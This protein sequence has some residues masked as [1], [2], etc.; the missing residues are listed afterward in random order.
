MTSPFSDEQIS[1]YLDGEL[2]VEET[3]RVE[4]QLRENADLRRLC[5][6]LRALRSTLQALPATELSEDLAERVLRQAERRMLL[7]DEE[8]GESLDGQVDASAA[9]VRRPHSPFARHPWRLVASV[10]AGLAALLLIMLWLP[11]SGYLSNSREV[12]TKMATDSAATPW[13]EEAHRDAYHDPASG[14][15]G[16]EL[17]FAL[18]DDMAAKEEAAPLAETE[19]AATGE[20]PERPALEAAASPDAAERGGRAMG[21]KAIRSTEPPAPGSASPVAGS[22]VRGAAPKSR[23]AN[24]PARQMQDS[25]DGIPAG[26]DTATDAPAV[27]GLGRAMDSGGTGYP[28]AALGSGGSGMGSGMGGY[29]GSG[30]GMMGGMGGAGGMDTGMGSGMGMGMGGGGK[31]NV[32]GMSG[33]PG[34][35]MPA[36][37]TTYPYRG[38]ARGSGDSGVPESESGMG[39]AGDAAQF[40]LSEPV[41]MVLGL[42][43]QQLPRQ[44]VAEQLLSE[45]DR[46]ESLILRVRVPADFSPPEL[47]TPVDFADTATWSRFAPLHGWLE[48]E[49]PDAR[50]MLG[51]RISAAQT[52]PQQMD[53]GPGERPTGSLLVVEGT[54]E[55]V[56]QSLVRLIT[57]SEVRLDAVS[58]LRGRQTQ[59]L[60]QDAASLPLVDGEQAG[61]RQKAAPHDFGAGLEGAMATPEPATATLDAQSAAEDK[62]LAA[63]QV[64]SPSDAAT[65][66]EETPP[67]LTEAEELAESSEGRR[68]PAA[69][70]EQPLREEVTESEIAASQ[71]KKVTADRSARD[72]EPLKREAGKSPGPARVVTFF[73]RYREDTAESAPAA[74]A[75]EK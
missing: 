24:T 49:K 34:A 56:R 27:L 11:I 31:A 47:S 35:G 64:P 63:G 73:F 17:R 53:Y 52:V 75:G 2:S 16:T 50:R 30:G 9:T 74:P 43:D 60:E 54:P 57:Q 37:S 70:A 40:D 36:E 25:S 29:P 51:E 44:R 69:A 61:V 66:R 14:G 46:H 18:E 15:A 38:E 7:G 22:L 3:A 67:K 41:E 21:R 48:Q 71:D 62:P 19:P 45:L 12:A 55:Q 20:R 26:A 28:G 5:D 65:E 1:A 6:Q 59:V 23:A 42:P 4:Q 10:L 13:A 33:L 58:A 68:P 72:Q 8:A 32:N 39:V